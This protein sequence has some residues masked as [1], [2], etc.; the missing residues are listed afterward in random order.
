MCDNKPVIL[1]PSSAQSI[2]ADGDAIFFMSLLN[3]RDI[4]FVIGNQVLG[5]PLVYSLGI[6]P[7]PLAYLVIAPGG[8]VGHIGD[9]KLIPKEKPEIAVA[10]ALAGQ[11]M[12]MRFVYLEAGSGAPEPVSPTMIEAV[13]RAC[14]IVLVVGG[15]IRT[16]EQAKTCRIAGAD[17]VV[18][19]TL[20]EEATDVEAV[21]TPLIMALKE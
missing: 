10:Y 18:T 4:S 14:D 3:S 12:G 15:G 17:V 20:V 13:K 7:I 2:S 5:A 8:T 1:F 6:E 21:L 9:A 19:G 16:P 11:Y